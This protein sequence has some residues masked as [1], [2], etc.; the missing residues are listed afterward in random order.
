MYVLILLASQIITNLPCP[1]PVLKGND[2]EVFPLF[3]KLGLGF[4]MQS[5]F[6]QGNCGLTLS[7]LKF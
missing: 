1:T 6:Y 7:I 3:T 4:R 2:F 5:T